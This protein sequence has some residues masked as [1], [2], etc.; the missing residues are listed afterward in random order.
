[1]LQLTT[2]FPVGVSVCRSTFMHMLG[3][4]FISSSVTVAPIDCTN[5]YKNTLYVIVKAEGSLYGSRDSECR[6]NYYGTCVHNA[7]FFSDWCSCKCICR[8]EASRRFLRDMHSR[9]NAISKHEFWI[10]DD[11]V[12]A[13]DSLGLCRIAVTNGVGADHRI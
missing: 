12:Q 10:P 6:E 5:R 9:G 1:M 11:E 7:P 2:S 13:T 3:Y 8:S 4:G